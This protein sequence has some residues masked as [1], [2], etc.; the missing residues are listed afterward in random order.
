M[1]DVFHGT[2]QLF[3]KFDHRKARIVNDF[4]GGGVAYFTDNK[5]VAWTYAKSMQKKNGGEQYLYYCSIRLNKIFDV[6]KKFTGDDL[7]KMVKAHGNTEEFALGS[8]QLKF[9][10]DKYI[11]INK[12]NEGRLIL[13]GDI[14]FKGLS[15]GMVNT[16]KAREIITSLGYDGL[17]Y[18]GG[19]NMGM[20]TKHNVY[21]VYNA[22]SISINL[23]EVGV[24]GK[25]Q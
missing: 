17:R 5:E 3:D 9:G 20:A 19:V 8:K 23:A 18:N 2:N 7:I 13:T 22:S 14:V 15:R 16:K 25:K 11:V 1:I 4:Y 24:K 10:M 12:L 21:L 6:D